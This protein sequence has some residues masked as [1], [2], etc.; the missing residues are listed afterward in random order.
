MRPE[1][2]FLMGLTGDIF[3]QPNFRH[4]ITLR[5]H[6]IKDDIEDGNVVLKTTFQASF[7]SSWLVK[8]SQVNSVPEPSSIFLSTF[9]LMAMIAIHYRK[10]RPLVADH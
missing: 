3:L 2:R 1:E 4:V 10:R 7:L 5:D 8:E 6:N 9:G